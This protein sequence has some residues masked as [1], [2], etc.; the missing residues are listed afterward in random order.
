MV[1]CFHGYD[2]ILCGNLV[3]PPFSFDKVGGLLLRIGGFWF[4]WGGL[5]PTQNPRFPRGAPI[6]VGWKRGLKTRLPSQNKVISIEKHH[7]NYY[8]S[9]FY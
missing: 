3:L 7:K 2:P 5:S 6:L 8:Y 9:I 1:F 4:V